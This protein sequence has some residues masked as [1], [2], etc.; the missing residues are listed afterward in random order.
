[1]LKSSTL[2]V[3]LI[4]QFP[5]SLFGDGG[6][7]RLSQQSGDLQISVF[8]S[9]AVLRCGAMD[10]SVLMQDAVTGK[11]RADVPAMVRLT[12]I[13]DRN[14]A[15]PT[16]ALEQLATTAAATNKLFRAATFDVPRSGNWRCSVSL[17][18]DSLGATE[19]D[20]HGEPLGFE[21]AVGPPAPAWLE[22]APWIGWP[23]ALIVLFL[24][25]QR[26]ASRARR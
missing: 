12:R 5:S 26:L 10:V 7:L 18:S 16:D 13:D 20:D 11:V 6:S 24:I 22:L 25:H 19:N 23:F 1:M 3:V 9:P 8:T 2:I 21:L 17:N 15:Q 14:G 4:L